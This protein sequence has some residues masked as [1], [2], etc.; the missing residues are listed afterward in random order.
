M[1][2]RL[3]HCITYRSSTVDLGLRALKKL[4]TANALRNFFTNGSFESSIW[5]DK[6]SVISFWSPQAEKTFGWTK[7]EIIGQKLT[8]TMVPKELINQHQEGTKNYIRVTASL[9]FLTEDVETIALHKDGTVIPIE[10]SIL[11]LNE[12]QDALFCAHIYDLRAKKEPEDQNIKRASYLHTILNST[13][14][15]ISATNQAG[16]A[17]EANE[18]FAHLWKIDTAQLD[19]IRDF[20]TV[21]AFI[22]DQI[23]NADETWNSN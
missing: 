15:G 6:D 7:D 13:D 10:L 9:L 4:T 2:K 20:K 16:E 1:G 5:Y 14:N 17:L 12:N 18:Q 3:L 23:E 11:T 19:I 8:D 21:A 22:Y